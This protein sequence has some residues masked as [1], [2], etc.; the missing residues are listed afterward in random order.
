VRP[1]IP[2]GT[3]RIVVQSQCEAPVVYCTAKTNSLGCVPKIGASGQASASAG[4]GFVISATQV[5]NK[6]AGL[7]LYGL[8]G[9]AAIPFQGGWFCVQ[10]QVWRTPGVQSGGSPLPVQDCSGVY[11]LDFNAVIHGGAGPAALQMP[12]T[13]VDCQWW[14][15]DP[16]FPAPNNTTLSDALE[17]T[18]CL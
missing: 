3:F 17:F 14:G 15:R 18:V 11:A 8:S 13:L 16:G 1:E 6:K 10:P 5:R 9:R 2:F 4:S 12:G 7:L